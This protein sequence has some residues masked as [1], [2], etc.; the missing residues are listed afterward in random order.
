MRVIRLTKASRI[1]WAGARPRAVVERKDLFEGVRDA[2]FGL[3]GRGPC[4]GMKGRRGGQGRGLRN[5]GVAGSEPEG[6]EAGKADGCPSACE[7]RYHGGGSG[8]ARQVV[9]W[10][11]LTETCDQMVHMDRD[12]LAFNETGHE[13][14]T[15]GQLPPDASK[16][17]PQKRGSGAPTRKRRHERA[18]RDLIGP[19][20]GVQRRANFPEQL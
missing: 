4:K 17:G 14:C 18:S 16:T 20:R 15:V 7:R 3:F 19:Q 6:M 13:W 9:R 1:P 2:L 10:P 8:R 12:W 5:L 11:G